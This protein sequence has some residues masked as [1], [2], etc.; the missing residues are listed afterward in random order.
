MVKLTFWI[1]VECEITPSLPL[2]QDQLWLGVVILARVSSMSPIDP[3]LKWFWIIL[4]HRLIKQWYCNKLWSVCTYFYFLSKGIKIV[5][6]ITMIRKSAEHLRT[7]FGNTFRRCPWCNGYRR[8]KWTRRH[9]FKSSTGLI[10]FHIGLIPLGKVWIQLLSLQLWV[11]SRTD[12][13]LQPW[14]GN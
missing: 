11:N 5:N 7:I 6:W 1:S 8:R 12:W 2:F 3:C 4:I 14:R 13:V 10:A 9:E